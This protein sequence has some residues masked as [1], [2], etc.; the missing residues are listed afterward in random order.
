VSEVSHPV[1]ARFYSRFVV[2]SMERYG[3]TELRARNLAGLRGTV[4]EVG[5]GDGAN[6]GLYPDSVERIV[7][8]EPE[9][10]LREKAASHTDERVQLRNA[11]AGELPVGDGEADA[12]VFSLVLCSID[13]TSALAEARRVLRPGGELRFLEHVQAPE[14]GFGRRLQRVLDATVWPRLAGGCHLSRDT[15]AAIEGA[16]FRVTEL[17]R[18]S[19]PEGARGPASFAVIGRAVRD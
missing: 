10:Y 19:F 2:P 17:E 12:V 15:A 13:Q 18:F 4:V 16:G 8:V 9:A 1:F 11:V 3:G 14:P 7:A 6:F 5:A